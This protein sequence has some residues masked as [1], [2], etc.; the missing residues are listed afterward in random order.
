MMTSRR[1]LKSVNC[2]PLEHVL[3]DNIY[4]NVLNKQSWYKAATCSC[5]T[6]GA[7]AIE[8][9]STPPSALNACWES[10]LSKKKYIYIDPEWTV[11]N[12]FPIIYRIAKVRV[13]FFLDA[14]LNRVPFWAIRAPPTFCSLLCPCQ[15]CKNTCVSCV[16]YSTCN[17]AFHK[18]KYGNTVR[19]NK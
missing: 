1:I 18:A 15:V 5:S 10:I 11:N 2:T 7:A 3:Y 12:I 16:L 4:V 9:E 19:K 14:S 17:D 13:F 8:N 6:V